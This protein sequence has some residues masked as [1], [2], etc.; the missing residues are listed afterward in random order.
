MMHKYNSQKFV[1]AM[2]EKM[3]GRGIPACDYCGGIQFTTTDKLSNIIIGDELDSVS[4]GPT[5][6]AGMIICEN[7]GHIEFFALGALG[8]LQ[9]EVSKNNE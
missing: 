3:S 7:C 8:L 4:L 1:E 9:A 2:N 6:P 5:I